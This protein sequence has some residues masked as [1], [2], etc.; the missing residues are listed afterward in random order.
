MAEKFFP[1]NKQDHLT[2]ADLRDVCRRVRNS[3]R[4]ARLLILD[5]YDQEAHRHLGYK[6]WSYLATIEFSLSCLGLMGLM[7]RPYA[8]STSCPGFD[9]AL[10]QSVA[11]KEAMA[12]ADR[13]DTEALVLEIWREAAGDGDSAGA[14]VLDL[15]ERNARIE[16]I[17]S[18]V[19]GAQP[20]QPIAPV[21]SPM[22]RQQA[23]RAVRLS[24]R[25]LAAELAALPR[26]PDSAEDR[27]AGELAVYL[28]DYS[29]PHA[30]SEK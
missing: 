5:L 27:L 2:V 19:P 1:K 26:T 7:L 15:A 3:I 18:L 16:R 11:Q 29:W 22:S 24:S 10:A 13:L 17:A 9:A 20:R 4:E 12:D 30:D 21:I 8:C 28:G 6:D 23:V 25:T 14:D